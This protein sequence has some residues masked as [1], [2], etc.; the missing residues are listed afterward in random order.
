MKKIFSVV[1]L[2]LIIAQTL[3]AQ[4]DDTTARLARI[5]VLTGYTELHKGPGIQFP[6]KDTFRTGDFF[7]CLVNDSDWYKVYDVYGNYKGE[8]INRTKVDIIDQLSAK[9]KIAIINTGFNKMRMMDSLFQNFN[10]VRHSAKEIRTMTNSRSTFV[11]L[12]Y[13]PALRVFEEYFVKTGDSVMFESFLSICCG[14]ADEEPSYALAKCFA[15]H[16]DIVVKELNKL[17]NKEAVR[18]YLGDIDFGLQNIFYTP[19]GKNSDKLDAIEDVLTNAYQTLLNR[20]RK[21]DEYE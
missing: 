16:P 14:D 17:S 9:E 18:L 5:K 3:S 8:Y 19:K 15:T 2:L 13:H 10:K 6:V 11:E 21:P 20:K 12:Q 7:Y 1:F 4:P